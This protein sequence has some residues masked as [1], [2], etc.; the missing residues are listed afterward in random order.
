VPLCSALMLT[1]VRRQLVGQRARVLALIAGLLTAVTGFT[2]LTATVTTS[3]L[4]VRKTVSGNFRGAYDILV[5]P[6]ASFTKL[7]RDRALV[8]DNYLS[9]IFGGITQSQWQ[10]V[11][12][13]PGVQVAAPIANVG[14]VTP[15]AQVPISVRPYL[16]GAPREIYRL[17][18]SWTADAGK[19]SF[20]DTTSYVYV[21]QNRMAVQRLAP[22]ELIPGQ[23]AAA[24][25]SGFDPVVNGGPTDP[26]DRKGTEAL[27]CLSSRYPDQTI[28]NANTFEQPATFVGGSGDVHFP[29]LIAA[30]DPEQEDKLLNLTGTVVNGRGLTDADGVEKPTNAKLPFP[31]IPVI[32]SSRLYLDDQLNVDVER[33]SVPAGTDV[34]T[35]LVSQHAR[36]FLAQLHGVPVGKQKLSVQPAYRHLTDRLRRK[37][38]QIDFYGLIRNYWTV[39]PANVSIEGPDRLS[40]QASP[41]PDPTQLW[42]DSF[43]A[44]AVAPPGNEDAQ[45]RSVAQQAG[46]S[47]SSVTGGSHSAVKMHIVG[48]F[49][50]Q[51]LPGFSD[52]S[53]VPLE[54]YYPPTVKDISSGAA[55]LPTMNVGGYVAQPPMVLTTIK[56]LTRLTDPKAYPP[57]D[58]LAP[59]P[60]SAKAPISVIRV[61]VVGVN[62]PD[63]AS[64]ERI[65]RVAQTIIA[66]TGLAVDVTIGSSP[67]DLSV[68]LP[69]G[70]YG[71]PAQVVREGWVQKGAAIA[72]LRHLDRKSLLLFVL[73][74]VV[75]T[76]FLINGATA[77]VRSRRSEIGVL[78]TFGWTRRQV[79][80]AIVLELISVGAIAGVAGAVLSA[81]L[82][83]TFDLQLSARQV[84]LVI[85]AAAALAAL[86]G[87][88]PA[89]DASRGQPL[90]AVR[91]A[92]AAGQRVGRVR[93][94]LSLGLVSLR[95]SPSRTALAAAALAVG[96]AAMTA[97]LAVDQSFVN[98]IAG[99]HLGSALTVEVRGVD[100]LGA[101]LAIVLGVA[102]V[103]DVLVLN[104]RE[105]AAELVTLRTFG[106]TDRQLA[107][108]ALY[109]G[110]GVG[111]LGT[112]VG[113]ALGLA[114]SAFAG[115]TALGGLFAAA[116]AIIVGT[117]MTTAIAVTAAMF[118]ARLPA[119]T[120]LAAE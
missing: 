90:D 97:L 76:F 117:A 27:S 69:A 116:A 32:A 60:V 34:V 114:I 79:F 45:F 70:T 23:G 80:S 75:C 9:G 67:H 5:R 115:A 89:W 72:V 2:L 49:D 53:R 64:Q 83:R 25:C 14:Y 29:L 74:L 61:R 10:A 37:S 68:A 26:F 84:L 118:I 98:R 19:S 38:D 46:S 78:R 33:L 100:Y 43:Q 105:R 52:L 59:L 82:A 92:V 63:K 71:R 18:K 17:R 41:P 93:G 48:T 6:A 35:E 4:R 58:A 96:V 24:V 8:R 7:E 81:G 107:K 21:T 94:L 3:E 31:Y 86:A 120:S 101:G 95:R 77:S 30:I 99:T 85:P 13:V 54:T 12:S 36:D 73:I 47:D 55:V 112:I 110:V 62:G 42:S 50:P 113:V 22:V 108:V 44:G 91:P 104:L 102:S 39:G 119:P 88:A 65:R 56:A 11:L 103:A 16:T 20:P 87:I 66:R 40:A 111:V 106:W 1:F 51:R 28:V 57:F 15:N 109:E